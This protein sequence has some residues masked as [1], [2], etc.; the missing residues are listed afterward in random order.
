MEYFGTFDHPNIVRYIEI[1]EDENYFFIVCECLKGSDII[2]QVW[3]V[4]RYSEDYAATILKQILQAVVYIH[5][6]G[7]AHN[8]L[9]PVNILH[10]NPNSPEIKIIDLDESGNQPIKDLDKFLR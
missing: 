10:V 7:V 2:E 1:Y 5:S 3:S 6:K 9:F 8:Q 4:G